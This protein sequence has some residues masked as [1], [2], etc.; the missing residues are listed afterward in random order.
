M[1]Q[2]K[3]FSGWQIRN[4]L[5]D[6]ADMEEAA[7][8]GRLDSTMCVEIFIVKIQHRREFLALAKECPD[9]L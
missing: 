4:I 9:M 5:E 6:A 3:G 2:S 8:T 7:K 1:D